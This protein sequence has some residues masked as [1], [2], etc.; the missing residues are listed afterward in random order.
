MSNF[1]SLPAPAWLLAV[2]C[3]SSV[4]VSPGLLASKAFQEPSISVFCT[5]SGIVLSL[6]TVLPLSAS[7]ILGSTKSSLSKSI[8]A[9][10]GFT[11]VSTPLVLSATVVS[12]SAL[13]WSVISFCILIISST[14]K[15]G[16][17]DANSYTSY[18]LHPAKN[19]SKA[20]SAT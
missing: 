17:I 8:T 18:S 11:G 2:A 13:Y 20:W 19:A 9:G 15:L 1:F 3:V 7:I 12:G 5:L 16:N 6:P 14:D 4:W 10:F